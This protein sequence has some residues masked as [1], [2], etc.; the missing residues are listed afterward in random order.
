MPQQSVQLECIS[1]VTLMTADMDRAARFYDS[2]GF[3][4]RYGGVGAAF[5]SFHVGPG[6]LNLMLGEPPGQ[7]W[8]RVILYVSDVDAMYRQAVAAGWR[9]AA[10]PSDAPWGERFFHLRDPDGN[11]LSFARPLAD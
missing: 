4:R 1:A 11:E 10:E 9:P 6:Y 8:G 2:L 3:R 7:L 5:T